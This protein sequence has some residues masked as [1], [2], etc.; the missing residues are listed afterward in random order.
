L[1][2]LLVKAAMRRF[3]AD[4]TPE[5][6]CIEGR[7][8]TGKTYA[9]DEAV[10]S[11]SADEQ[12]GL[13]SYAYISLFGLKDA[14]DIV[15]SI[16][17]NTIDVAEIAK[18]GTPG[19]RGGTDLKGK[20]KAFGAFAADH[21]SVPHIAGLGGIARAVLANFVTDTVVCIDDFE[22]RSK[23]VTVNE[24]MGTVA[25]LRD[26]RNCKVVL[27]LNDNSLTDEEKAEFHRFSEKVINRSFQFD[28]TA[29]EAA[30]IAFP[31]KDDLSR[32]LRQAC[33]ELGIV[34]IRLMAKIDRYARD[35]MKVIREVDPTVAR[36]VMRSLV[37][38]V[39][40]M[41]SPR[42]E[43]APDLA[44]LKRRGGLFVPTDDSTSTLEEDGWGELLAA[45]GFTSCDDFDH[46][47]IADVRNGYFDEDRVRAGAADYLVD[48]EN[49][50]ARAAF[51]EAW[52]PFHASFDDNVDEVAQSI[53]G[54]CSE[55]IAHLSP[56]NLSS[57]I[58]V[59]KDIG[60]AE[61]AHK[62]LDSYLSARGADD[63]FDLKADVF[64]SE[65]R[66]PDVRRAFGEKTRALE[67]R[68]P[69][70]IE[71][72]KRIR[73]HEWTPLDEDCLDRYSTEQFMSLF[74]DEKADRSALI[75]GC[76]EFGKIGGTTPR[77]RGISTRAQEALIRIGAE[78][79]L[80]AYRLRKYNV[81]M[82]VIPQE[83]SD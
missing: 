56:M 17:A 44:Y 65:I 48:V 76:L 82:P 39:W 5:V 10:R 43:G 34:N 61:L 66:D 49:T 9:W 47:M 31:A 75:F 16:Y 51:E 67:S 4:P 25:Q 57:A 54:G 38:I 70:P 21:A 83:R 50:R 23:E 81:G 33:E 52:K 40:S 18:P 77:Q 19:R 73:R 53:F 2:V 45:Y 80:N 78:S 63:V 8:G 72:A 6:L 60:R 13:K 58:T 11:A 1:S 12:V 55:N 7:W 30:A 59:L 64:G 79:P 69:T 26:A 20:L 37:V 68:L 32:D 36:N 35:L 74:K 24:I 29:A 14:S 42:G 71:A 15:Q 46:V 62:L 28:P 3:L 27:I 22:R 41:L